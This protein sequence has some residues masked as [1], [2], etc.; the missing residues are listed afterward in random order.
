M[1]AAVLAGGTA[2]ACSSSGSSDKPRDPVAAPNAKQVNIPAYDP[3]KGARSDAVPGDCDRD[4]KGE[5]KFAGVVNNRSKNERTYSIVVDFVLDK[6]N[7]VVDTKVVKVPG[8]GA[9]H[10]ADWTTIGASGNDDT[11][12]CV[13]RNVQFS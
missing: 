3:T 10:T 12:R 1:T 7:T 4:D 11:L 6:G 8:V 13:I 9:G 5:W 2:T